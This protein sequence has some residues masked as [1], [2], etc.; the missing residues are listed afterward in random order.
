MV[1]ASTVRNTNRN[2]KPCSKLSAYKRR[3]L[4]TDHVRE[5]IC[6]LKMPLFDCRRSYPSQAG[7]KCES[8]KPGSYVRPRLQQPEINPLL[9]EDVS[10][11]VKWIPPPWPGPRQ[12]VAFWGLIN[13]MDVICEMQ[14]GAPLSSHPL[15]S[16]ERQLRTHGSC[17]LP[18][19]GAP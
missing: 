3:L 8:G 15:S 12:Y 18:P 17:E 11:L 10:A 14:G 4:G 6:S 2:K 13:M 19:S 5:L 16:T 1:Q 9:A 7:A